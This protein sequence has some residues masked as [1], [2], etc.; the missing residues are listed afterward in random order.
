MSD[1]RTGLGSDG[2]SVLEDLLATPVGRRWALKAGL[3]SAAALGVGLHAETGSALTA[4][5]RPSRRVERTD[6]HFVFGHVHGVSG[7]TLVANGQRI[8][9]SRHTK[10]SRAALK[11]RGGLWRHRRPIEALALR[12][13]CEA[14]GGSRAV[15]LGA[16]QARTARGR[17]RTDDAR[18]TRVD[19]CLCQVDAPPD[20]VLPARP[21]FAPAARG[22]RAQALADSLGGAGCAARDDPRHLYVRV[23]L[24]VTASEHREQDP[25]PGDQR[26]AWGDKRGGVAREVHPEAGA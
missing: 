24:R 5:R 17:G 25:R 22:A 13:G 16:R 3:G 12:R 8:L 19:A 4:P 15:D 1:E 10:V 14:A 21:R 18:A 2:Q 11:R 6:L 23:R 7:L 26:G 9:L 20:W